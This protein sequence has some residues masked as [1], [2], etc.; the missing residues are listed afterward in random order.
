MILALDLTPLVDALH[1][2]LVPD[3]ALEVGPLATLARAAPGDGRVRALPAVLVIQAEAQASYTGVGKR[4]LLTDEV[5]VLL[6]VRVPDGSDTDAQAR[7]SALRDAI[8]E[9]L[10]QTFALPSGWLSIQYQGGRWLGVDDAVF[11]WAERYRITRQ[12]ICT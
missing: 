2:A 7:A 12:G 11:S 10:L 9:A 3:L 5:V 4:A 1:A 6:R 8:A